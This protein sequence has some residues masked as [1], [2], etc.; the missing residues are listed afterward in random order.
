V[1]VDHG[2]MPL[3]SAMVEP[4]TPTRCGH[5]ALAGRPNVGKSTLLN[6]L[7]GEHL[8]LVSPKAQATR[9]PVTGILTTAD[10]Q[11]VLHDLPGLLDPRYAL[12]QSMRAAALATLDEVD[13]ILHLV[14]AND[15][16]PMSF[17]E[18]TGL[19]EWRG[20]PVLTVFTKG[21]LV[22]RLTRGDLQAEGPVV[23]TE[24]PDSIRR[25]VALLAPL[26]P[27]G[28]FQ[29]SPDDIGTQPV[30][31]FATEYVRE[32][33]FE[34]LSQELPYAVA[35]EVEEFRENELPVYIRLSILV[36]RESQKAMV[37]GRGGATI[38]RMGSHA[39][40][41]LERLLGQK[42]YLDL[43]VKVVKNWRKRPEI[44][45]RLGFPLAEETKR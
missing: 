1:S 31:F 11:L 4:G 28:P 43:W 33:A 23:T 3:Y 35:V 9:L 34:L 38:K 44:L 7:V 32:A 16:P 15:Y 22:D 20:A 12:Q 36:E 41:R 25:L 18:E 30:R 21:D 26:V 13:V 5:V 2:G 39:R 27:K 14:A 24:D 8:A 40:H 29:Y 42:V 10:T 19:D 17:A 6:A 45:A 37:I